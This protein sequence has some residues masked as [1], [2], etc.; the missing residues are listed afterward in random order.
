MGSNEGI[1]AMAASP[2]ISIAIIGSGGAGALTTGDSSCSKRPAAAGWHGLFTRTM[3]PQIRG[4]EAAALLRL[5]VDPVESLPDQ[6]DLLIGIDWLNAHRF[7]AEI[8][9]GPQTLVISDPRGG[10]LPPMVVA[11]RR[12]RRRSSD[13][14]DGQGHSRR[15]PQ[16]DR[17]RHCQPAAGLYRRSGFR[18][19]QKTAYRQGIGRHRGEPRRNQGRVRRGSR[20]RF[21]HASRCAKTAN[22]RA[23]GCCQA[24]KRPHSA[25]S[26]VAFA[27]PPLIRSHQQPKS[28]NGS[29]RTL[30][31]SAERCCRP[32]TNSPLST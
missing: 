7:G 4:G 23:A 24:T 13:E 31:K 28:S 30:P 25:P 2:S 20:H 15:A 18:T 5:A 9:A 10:D 21:R 26:A 19:D 32:K 16:H 12:P 6:F 29:R 27:L 11:I 14:G 22:R 17:A 1:M 8:K 3:G